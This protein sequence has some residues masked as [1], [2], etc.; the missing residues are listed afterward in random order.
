MA[1]GLTIRRH[2]ALLDRM[3]HMPGLDL[4]GQVMRGLLDIDTWGEAVLRS[5]GC[6]D[7]GGCEAWLQA[8]TRIA[9]DPRARCRNADLFALQKQGRR[10]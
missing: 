9:S 10:V 3:A 2:A 8:R 1:E 6:A 7:P 4:A 5:V